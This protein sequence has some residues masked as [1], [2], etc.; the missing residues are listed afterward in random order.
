MKKHIGTRILVLLSVFFLV[1]A[2]SNFINLSSLDCIQKVNDEIADDYMSLQLLQGDVAVAFQQVQLY[3]NLSYFKVGTGE[4]DIVQ[5]KLETAIT[6]LTTSVSEM[7][8]I[9]ERIG[10]ADL[11]AAYNAWRTECETYAAF[12]TGI[13]EAAIADQD[14]QVVVYVGQNKAMKEP[15]DAA[16][17]VYTEA[18]NNSLSAVT[19]SS[20]G[21]T[22]NARMISRI[23][24]LVCI[25]IFAVVIFVVLKTI[26]IPARNSG[27]VMNEIID[28]IHDGNG[29]LTR[30]L[31]ATTK[32]E[33]GQLS[34][35]MNDFIDSLQSIVRTLKENAGKLNASSDDVMQKL[36]I[37]N[38][39]TES[40][41]ATMEGMSDEMDKMMNT[42][43]NISEGSQ[44]IMDKVENMNNRVNEGTELV[45][46]IK[47]RARK[48][49]AETV[50]S[51][52]E[53]EEN[54]KVVR[55]NLLQALEESRSVEKINELTADILSISSQTNLLSLNASIEAARA[56]EAGR[57]FA[58][59]ADEIRALAESSASSANNIQT[60]S[61]QVIMAVHMLTDNA[62]SILRMMDEK[63]LKD[64]DGF[65]GTIEQYV[66][67]ADDMNSLLTE[68]AGATNDITDAVSDVNTGITS[69]SSV[70]EANTRGVES[71]AD[72]LSE[73]AENMNMIQSTMQDNLD[74][75]N[76][77]SKEVARFTNV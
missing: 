64:Y 41:S 22:A 28:G 27:K 50:R 46:D 12:A 40:I 36:N 75:S 68:F 20:K 62:E 57:G 59:V 54:V 5:G 26:A 61:E 32:D 19:A 65:V 74:L 29:D 52:E 11:T 25:V 15:C 45:N 67:D 16:E 77:L 9:V 47:K 49:Q 70:L 37:S 8:A 24:L 58:V 30:R 4:E 33:V 13:Y 73:L 56:G 34:K 72:N 2:G 48:M 21:I 63:V 55:E 38:I 1:I 3:A 51:K 53:T 7:E 60:I 71:V 23:S 14:D 43:E 6:R 39:S 31:P 35:G 44:N 66:T 42:V 18:Y 76:D 10:N 17:A 69:M